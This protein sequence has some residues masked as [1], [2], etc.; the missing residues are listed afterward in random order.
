MA[1]HVCPKGFHSAVSQ[2][3]WKHAHGPLLQG[4][5]ES[6][7]AGVAVLQHSIVDVNSVHNVAE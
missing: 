7:L 3:V 4:V 2:L 6:H 1:L 5:C